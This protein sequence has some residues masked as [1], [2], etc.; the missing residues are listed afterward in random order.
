METLVSRPFTSQTDLQPAIEL[1]STCRA[2]EA[3]DP[4][5]PIYDLRERLRLRTQYRSEDTQIWARHEGELAALATIWDGMA[6]I[7]AIHPR[8]LSEELTTEILAWGML[9]A[10][11]IGLGS[12]IIPAFLAARLSVV[13]GLRRII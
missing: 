4:W 11:G 12:G 6:L 1:V 8:S 2:V 3:I 9:V 10:A 5:P 7:F 13:D